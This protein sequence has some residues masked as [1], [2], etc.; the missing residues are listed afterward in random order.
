MKLVNVAHIR[1]LLRHR[2]GLVY[3]VTLAGIVGINLLAG[4]GL[5]IATAVIA[6]LLR[7]G[8]VDIRLDQ[9]GTRWHLTVRGALTFLGVP[10]LSTY[11]G[12]IP[13]ART[14]TWTSTSRFID[15]AGFEALHAWRLSHER[16]GGQVDI[17]QLHEV[18]RERPAEAAPTVKSDGKDAIGDLV[19]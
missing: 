18:W 11:L 19:C 6:L 10:K 9:R 3:F 16:S 14:S 13:P 17:D 8:K 7:L 2:E 15:H 4:I 12:R 5:G 1:E